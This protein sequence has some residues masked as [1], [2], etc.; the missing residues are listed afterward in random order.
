MSMDDDCSKLVFF[1]VVVEKDSTVKIYL[2]RSNQYLSEEEKPVAAFSLFRG[3]ES[4]VY[5]EYRIIKEEK[6]CPTIVRLINSEIVN[7]CAA[8]DAFTTHFRDNFDPEGF[9]YSSSLLFAQQSVIGLNQKLVM[10]KN[11]ID[12][13]QEEFS[14]EEHVVY[15]EF[16]VGK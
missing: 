8:V 9:V 15:E 6:I 16:S 7:V 14:F 12:L 1:E 5:F 10:F 11:Q 4:V 13:F 2:R 3:D